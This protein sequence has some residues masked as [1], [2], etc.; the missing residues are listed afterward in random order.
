MKSFARLVWLLIVPLFCFVQAEAGQGRQAFVVASVKAAPG[1]DPN[2]GSWSRPGVGQFTATH[3]SLTRLL[4][5][6]YGVD[7]SQIANRPGWFDTDL[8]DVVAKPEE[9]IAMTREELQPRLQQLLQERF[10]LSMHQEMRQARGYALLVASGGP[11][12][13]PTLGDHFPGFRINVS[14][15]EMRGANW[16]MAVLAKYL[17]SAVGFP[18][19]DRTDLGGSYDIEFSYAPETDVESDL[20]SLNDALRRATGLLLKPEKVPVET[21]VVDTVDRHVTAN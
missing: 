21:I 6:A 8:F 16:S 7:S 20:P 13:K 3:V 2:T 9:G 12:L 11:H 10:H 14:A 5:L 18:V 17:T 19:I 4:Q 1:A 15:G